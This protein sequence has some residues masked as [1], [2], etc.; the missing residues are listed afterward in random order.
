MTNKIKEQK[1]LDVAGALE[2]FERYQGWATF[3]T[4][5][6]YWQQIQE[7]EKTIRETLNAVKDTDVSQQ[8]NAWQDI[9]TASKDGT[10]ILGY[11]FEDCSPQPIYWA[12]GALGWYSDVTCKYVMP[13]HWMPIPTP[14]DASADIASA[15]Q[16]SEEV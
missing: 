2:A 14:P 13:T 9:S 4:Q 1:A 6:P 3:N 16:E 12:E 10:E 11:L 8:Y 7:D 15:N 5:D